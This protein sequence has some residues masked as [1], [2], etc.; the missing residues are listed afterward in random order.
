MSVGVATAQVSDESGETAPVISAESSGVTDGEIEARIGEIFSEIDALADIQIVVDAGVVSLSGTVAETETLQRAESLASRVQGVVTVENN[1]ARDLSVRGRF[2]PAVDQVNELVVKTIALLPLLALAAVVFLALIFAGIFIAGRESFW[3]R[4]TPNNFVADL[5]Q[6][7]VKTISVLVAVVVTLNLLDATALLSAVLGS[8]GVIGLALG[9]AVRD[10]IEN[11]IASI[12]LSLRQPFRPRD[13]V[14]INGQ[15]G[16]AVRLTSRA[17]VLRDLDGNQ[18]RIPNAEVFKARILN[19][20]VNPE[21]RFSFKLGVD[22]DDDPLKAIETGVRR[23]KDLEFILDEPEPFA[24]INEVGDSNI[25]IEYY[26]W[27][28][29]REA[30]FG[31]SRSIALAAVKAALESAGFMLPEPIYRLR[32]DSPAVAAALQAEGEGDAVPA[33]RNKDDRALRVDS[34]D[35][36]DVRPDPDVERQVEAE[37]RA[38]EHQDLLSESA[39]KE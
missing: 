10:S 13:H 33:Y 35:E 30:D 7:S 4:V 3:Q 5:A 20:T 27:I 6:T 38:G 11:Y 23:L 29:Q 24:I 19:Y 22:A 28:D 21:R 26:S 15:E 17:T 2:A 9:F 8:A 16:Y 14:V 12:L 36:I 34:L 31:K 37:R 1:L 18:L 32:F 39:P 25:V